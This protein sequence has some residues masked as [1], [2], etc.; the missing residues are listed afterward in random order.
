METK[1]LELFFEYPLFLWGLALLP[2]LLLLGIYSRYEL[3]SVQKI[4]SVGFR[5]LIALLVVLSLS[6]LQARVQQERVAVV[7]LMD[8]SESIHK[9]QL[10]QGLQA[11]QAA[12]EKAGPRD[13]SALVVFG[14]EVSLV[15]PFQKKENFRIDLKHLQELQKGLDGKDTDLSLALSFARALFPEGYHKK[16]VLF[17][18]GNETVRGGLKEA[19]L[20]KG[21][22]IQLLVQGLTPP[23]SKDLDVRL[24]D[25]TLSHRQ[26]RVGEAI[27]GRILIQS[28]K[29]A[30]GELVLYKNGIV[31]ERRTVKIK[32][33]LNDVKDFTFQDTLYEKGMNLYEAVFNHKDDRNI[34]NNRTHAVIYGYSQ[35]L[36]VLVVEMEEEHAA[37]LIEGLAKENIEAE[38]LKPRNLGPNINNYDAVI[39]SDVP[40]TELKSENYTS[41][42]MMD[43]IKSYVR[44]GGGFI[45]VGGPESFGLGGYMDTELEKILPVQMDI[46]KKIE[47][48]TVAIVLVLDKS[49][50]MNGYGKMELAKQACVKVVDF[51]KPQDWI[52]V[53]AFDSSYYWATDLQQASGRSKII[54]NIETITASGGTYIYPALNQAYI[55]LNRMT[56]AKIRHIILLTDGRTQGGAYEKISK[57]IR[58]AGITL[59]TVA[60]GQGA[61]IHLLRNMSRWGGGRYY[62]TKNSRDIPRIFTQEA[63]KVSKSSIVDEPFKPSL[64][65]PMQYLEGIDWESA[66]E[67]LSYVVTRPKKTALVSL[68]APH[69][70]SPE[71]K[72]LL[73]TW[74][75]GLGKTAAFTSD[76]KSRWAALWMEWEGFP[77]FWAQVLRYIGKKKIN[78]YFQMKIQKEGKRASFT[79]DAADDTH[80]FMNGRDF[81]VLL[82]HFEKGKKSDAPLQTLS[83]I[84]SA[85]GR[86]KAQVEGLK[87]GYY[88]A[89]LKEKDKPLE[90]Q[91]GGFGVTDVLEHLKGN[92]NTPLLKEMSSQNKI[93]LKAEETWQKEETRRV[94]QAQAIWPYLLMMALFLLPLDIAVRRIRFSA[95]VAKIPSLPLRPLEVFIRSTGGVIGAGLGLFGGYYLAEKYLTP[96]YWVFWGPLQIHLLAL[97]ISLV[98]GVLLT[99]AGWKLILRERMF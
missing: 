86:Y 59:S 71:G 27:K 40:V 87:E 57:D 53:V 44:R 88:A 64:G 3:P 68:L 22:G 17:T 91:S 46:P 25:M 82:Y 61:D 73:A 80:E 62:F 34:K 11:L 38:W 77:K 21:A 20:V 66:P 72:P 56:S 31:K 4:L 85:P 98:M 97:G 51:L 5:T 33:G 9:E 23:S 48:P 39:L 26:A 12:Q 10:Q 95:T 74:Q 42:E 58:S 13:V 83:L 89:V 30:E 32:K 60:V 94:F 29:D 79:V 35:K 16:I 50:S 7:Y 78:S 15:I 92:L 24:L 63:M 1:A 37:P 84:Q 65:I 96:F 18:D 36:K 90:L 52:G 69:P 8:L 43:T 19:R 76:A 54:K 49:G 99:L 41:D 28:N 2:V 14:A 45:M 70:D 47:L 67:L 55:K 81:Q 6:G 93:F 75:V